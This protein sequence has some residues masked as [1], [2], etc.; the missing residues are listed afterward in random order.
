MQATP[1]LYSYY[2]PKT[3][4]PSPTL[5]IADSFAEWVRKLDERDYSL[6]FGGLY[7]SNLS[8]LLVRAPYSI[9]VRLRLGLQ[10]NTSL[11]L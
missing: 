3:V 5:P 2:A 1:G 6:S 11:D 4:V 9:F 7:D 8:L 10:R